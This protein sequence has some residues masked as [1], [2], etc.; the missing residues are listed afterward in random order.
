MMDRNKGELG[1]QV[2]ETLTLGSEVSDVLGESTTASESLKMRNWK[3]L[4][5]IIPSQYIV[6]K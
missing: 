3:L 2:A 1:S 6:F 5:V 4:A